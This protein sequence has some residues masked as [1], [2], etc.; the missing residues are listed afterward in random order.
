MEMKI[1]DPEIE[2]LE[3]ESLHLIHEQIQ[4]HDKIVVAFSGGK[5]STLILHLARQ[6]DCDIPAVFV[7]TGVEAP[8]TYEYLRT[9]ENLITLKNSKGHTFWSL[10]DKYGWPD[11]KGKQSGRRG[12]MC[13]HYLKEQPMK[14]AIKR[15]GWDL[16]ID[17]LTIA[18][19]RQR[20]MFLK[21]YGSYHWVI[22]W[23]IQ[24]LHPIMDWKPLQVLAY[25]RE[26]KIPYN[27]IYDP[28]K[29]AVRVGCQPCTAYK[30]W[31][32]RLA[33]ENPKLFKLVLE[34]KEGIEV[35]CIYDFIEKEIEDEFSKTE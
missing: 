7:D 9:V 34:R 15:E 2:R 30:S 13:C 1:L 17:G 24:K 5:D 16:L 10:V 27:K 19:S 28:P 26:K 35:S 6:V 33:I 29:S 32:H 3:K 21:S 14:Q 18:E 25:L 20:M 8:E 11:L 31:K 12:N 23:D 4:N 22:S